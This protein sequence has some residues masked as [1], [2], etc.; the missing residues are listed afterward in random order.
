MSY[1][2]KINPKAEE[3]LARQPEPLHSFIR[4]SL[5][6]FA[7]SPFSFRSHIVPSRRDPSL[8]LRFEA[9]GSVLWVTIDYRFGADEQTLHVEHIHVEFGA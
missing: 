7:E 9:P 3:Q 8:E 2:L 5:L 6:R 1:A 4:Q